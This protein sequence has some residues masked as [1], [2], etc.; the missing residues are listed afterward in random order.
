MNSSRS[1]LRLALA[2]LALV[3]FA[4]HAAPAARAQTYDAAADYSASAA[5][6]VNGVWS[7]G[8]TT[9]L[10][11]TLNL[12]DVNN[13]H[14][15]S[16]N[17]WTSSVVNSIDTP[18]F[19][20]NLG[21]ATQ[22]STPPGFL[23]HHPGPNGVLSVLR[24]TAP[25]SSS[26]MI[27]TQFFAGDVGTTEAYVLLNNVTLFFSPTTETAPQYATSLLLAAGDR[28]DFVVGTTDSFFSDTTPLTATVTT[29]ATGVV[30]EPGALA[31]AACGL[32]PIAGLLLRRRRVQAPR[33]SR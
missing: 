24:F 33:Q 21:G 20:K 1:R 17:R 12:Y 9:A 4:L 13:G 28:L 18:S 31:L 32:L 14:T 11:A 23:F 30:P 16:I 2:P 19:G 27:S 26:Y 8:Y 5:T 6:N 22:Q 15:N 25:S 7:Y 10:G 3:A 29:T